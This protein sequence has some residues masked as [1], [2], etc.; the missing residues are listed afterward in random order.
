MTIDK[1]YL[2]DLNDELAELT[3]HES[4]RKGKT[5]AKNKRKKERHGRLINSVHKK[6]HEILEDVNDVKQKMIDYYNRPDSHNGDKQLGYLIEMQADNPEF[7]SKSLCDASKY[8][9]SEEQ[10]AKLLELAY[11]YNPRDFITLTSYATAL[12]ESG[13]SVQAFKLFKESLQLKRDPITLTS[14]ATALVE[15]GDSEQ[16]FKLFEESLQLKRDAITLNSYAIALVESGDSVQA[17]KLFDE[18]LQLKRNTITLTSYAIVLANNGDNEQAFKLFEESLQLKRDPI[19]LNSY[20]TALANIGDT[21]Q[22]F[23]LFEE[24]LQ[25]KR[26]P[27][28]LTSYA[29][30]LANSGDSELAFKLLEESLQLKRDTITLTSYASALIKEGLIEEARI[31]LEM[32]LAINTQD[33]ICLYLYGRLLFDFIR[34]Y[35]TSFIYLQRVQRDKMPVYGRV[36]ICFLLGQL[37][38]LENQKAQAEAYF[39]EAIEYSEE[40]SRTR[41]E[42]AQHILSDDPHSDKA[43]EILQTIDEK[44]RSYRQAEDM[45]AFH[46]PFAAYYKKFQGETY[47]DLQMLNRGIYHKIQNE[48]S[49]LKSIA[50][51][52]LLK[53]TDIGLHDEVVTRLEK[54]IATITINRTQEQHSLETIENN[55][56]K[57]IEEAIATTVHRIVDS[58]N[59]ELAT[60]KSYARRMQLNVSQEN[61]LHTKLSQLLEQIEKSETAL[62][63]LKAVNEGM[64]LNFEYFKIAELFTLWNKQ[65]L[66]GNANLYLDVSNEDSVF[67]G[68]YQKLR[69][70]INEIIENS[71]KHNPDIPLTISITSKDSQYLPFRLNTPA[72][73][74]ERFLSIII[75]DNGK[76]I[77]SDKKEWVFF[78]LNSTYPESSGLGL[79][80]VKKTIEAM[81]GYVIESGHKGAKFTIYLPYQDNENE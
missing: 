28:T 40:G 6:P 48:I 27:I 81:N 39:A 17:F 23:K 72:K 9:F 16:A 62:N 36:T 18:S 8:L 71:L 53:E 35:S 34:D 14:Y 69:A 79:F 7:L 55:D 60:V 52:I 13:D 38:Y 80:L 10:Q 67:K 51:R 66:L 31:Q 20:A 54:I 78:P 15:S 5:A 70:C 41:L 21:E 24:S 29:T 64:K 3:L 33:N 37:A 25:L 26:A 1:D 73:N 61:S 47:Y 30:T 44:H 49:I 77:A 43:F 76:G 4:N 2:E 42:V 22:A 56:L 57:A 63:E 59:N 50:Q 68:D 65:P 74:G 32:A 45:L 46:L 12:V 75:S 58:V 11:K 19:T